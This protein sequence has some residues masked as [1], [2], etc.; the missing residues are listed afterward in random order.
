[1]VEECRVLEEDR[2]LTI[3]NE[4]GDVEGSEVDDRIL[5]SLVV[6]GPREMVEAC[7]NIHDQLPVDRDI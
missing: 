5:V 6:A 7:G 1:V 2:V 4:T 3:N